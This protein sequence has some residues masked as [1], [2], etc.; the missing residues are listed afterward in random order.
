MVS[1]GEMGWDMVAVHDRGGS[2][3]G[4]GAS[5]MVGQSGIDRRK[6]ELLA[7]AG[8]WDAF[9]AALEAGADAIYLGLGG[10]NARHGAE[11]FTVESLSE[12][13]R[14]AHLAGSRV[15]LTLNTLLFTDEVEQALALLGEAWLAGIDAVIVQDIGL[16][17]RI[18]S[19]LPE[20]EVHTS[21]QMNLCSTPGIALAKRLGASRVTLARELS[22]GEIA[23][24]AR[25]GVDLEVF[26][27]GALCVCYSGQCLMSSLIGRRSANRGMC[28]QPCRL[29]WALVDGS[30]AEQ[31]VPG[32]HLLSTKDLCTVDILPQL[33]DAQVASLKV[34]GRMKSPEYV[35]IVCGVYRSC[36]DRAWED[37]ESYQVTDDEHTRLAEAFSR[38]FT[39]AYLEGERGNAMMSYTR[40]NNRGIAVGRVLRIRGGRVGLTLTRDIGT[41]DVLEFWTRRGKQV[42][43]VEEMQDEMGDALLHA[44]VDVHPSMVVPFPVAP[45]D[46]VFRVRNAGLRS[47]VRQGAFP[48]VTRPLA[49]T[50]RVRKGMPL[51][52]RVADREGNVG[53]ARGK[54]IEAARTKAVTSKEV[55]E[56]IG[57]LGNTAYTVASMEVDLDEGVGLGFSQLHRVRREAIAD[58]EARI[59]APWTGREPGPVPD[60]PSP[61]AQGRGD[62]VHGKPEAAA[63]VSCAETLEAA[64]GA[65]ARV[66]YIPDDAF[67]DLADRFGSVPFEVTVHRLMPTVIHDRQWDVHDR[68]GGLL[69][70]PVVADDAATLARLAG[71]GAAVEAGPHVN[72]FNRDSLLQTKALGARRL[73][74]SPELSLAQIEELGSLRVLPLTL[75]VYGRQELMV[76]EHCVLQALGDC[77]RACGDCTRRAGSFMLRDGKGYGFPVTTDLQSR[78]HIHNSV[79][80]D[81]IPQ[82]PQLARCMV[83]RFVVDARLLSGEETRRAL[84]RLVD[85]LHGCG[86][87]TSASPLVRDEGTT[88][89]HLFRGV[90]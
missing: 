70:Y 10:F 37:P 4:T 31:Q 3:D 63:I 5:G 22:L 34:E 19:F 15:Y 79:P 38:G 27:H 80:L 68:E 26:A 33:I 6:P 47:G 23:R 14:M 51:E 50:V 87:D 32:E 17:S 78:S 86:S 61:F 25:E 53:T 73:W 7:P 85:A 56:H 16:V 35:S 89:G 65:G 18:R 20:L 48:G 43:T 57:R 74:L 58:Y 13:C 41:G 21:T 49:F 60:H 76:T 30:G 64:V 45:G 29:P 44:P 67:G 59:L 82:V 2:L 55:A 81:I 11:N 52:L 77:R 62:A 42:L 72:V 54:V 1:A 39:T 12:A 40:P 8:S 46:R 24:L 66:L 83:S 90:L 71:G 88:T 69:T 28:A 75:T 84:M 36:I 9:C